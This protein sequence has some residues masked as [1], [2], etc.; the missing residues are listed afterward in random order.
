MAAQDTVFALTHSGICATFSRGLT[1]ATFAQCSTVL[2]SDL[3]NMNN[4][5]NSVILSLGRHNQEDMLPQYQCG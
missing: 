1:R 4:Y 2:S 5:I 3:C